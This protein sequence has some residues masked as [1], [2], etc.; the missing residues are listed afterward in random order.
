MTGPQKFRA[1]CYTLEGLN[2]FATV[3]YFN[4]LYFFFR[5]TFGFDNKHNLALAAGIGVVYTFCSWQ[6][7][8]LAARYG[9]FTALKLGFGLMAAGLL[10]GAQLHTAA[11]VIA[12][13]CVVNAGTCLIWPT[14]EAMVSEGAVAADAVGLYNI[15]WAATNAVAYFIGGTLIEQ[16]GYR[17]LFYVPLGLMLLQ[18]GIV[19]WLQTLPAPHDRPAPAGPP[20]AGEARSAPDRTL[21]KQMG[22]LANPFAYIAINTLLAV[23]PGLAAKFQLSPMLAG[24]TC[25]LW[26]FVRLGM[27]VFLWLWP[28]W[29]YR[30]RWLA[31][32]FGLLVASFTTILTAPS[33]PLLL[34]AQIVFGGAI[35]LIYYSSLFYSMD[36]SDTKSEHGGIHEAAIG[37]GN[38]LGPGLGAVSLQYLPQHPN[39]GAMA[40]S[41]LL[42]C[43]FGGLFALRH[44]ARLF[45][46]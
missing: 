18:L 3:I 27:F 21:F 10:V 35:G 7:G 4:Y 32:A 29:H 24:F 2:S 14:I 40:V 11:G 41:V 6:S 34:A 37:L 46:K 25:S 28:G 5:H 17:S 23:M 39:S 30:F 26:C 38:C 45:Q 36:A 20:A 1:T 9:Y 19:F 31:T 8:R 33:L 15:T 12:T 42:L 13:A 16:W 22:W 44:R 43:G